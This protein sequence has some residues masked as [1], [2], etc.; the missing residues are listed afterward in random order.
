M[1]L[2]QS[3]HFYG[4][5]LSNGTK[6]YTLGLRGVA[7]AKSDTYTKDILKDLNTSISEID[8]GNNI[9]NKVNKIMTDRS[10][11]EE[12]VNKNLS[13]DIF[14]MTNSLPF[15]SNVQYI[16]YYNLDRSVKKG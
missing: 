11:T 1:L 7:D 2:Q 6:A 10:S 8:N 13:K 12:N 15:F 5:E 16:H 3:R 14:D 4:V 9:L